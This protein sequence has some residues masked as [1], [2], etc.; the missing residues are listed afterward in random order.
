MVHSLKLACAFLLFA[1]PA[2]A[3]VGPLMRANNGSDIP[4]PAT[5]R[6]NT[7]TNSATNLTTGTIPVARLPTNTTGFGV[8]FDGGGSAIP[9]GTKEFITVPF[10]CTIVAA[11]VRLHATGSAVIDIWKLAFSTSANPTVANTI[12]ASDKPTVSTSIA[13][14][15]TS[16]TSW[17]T[18]ITAGDVIAFNVDSTDASKITAEIECVRT[19]A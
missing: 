3:Q 7:G 18:A 19:G 17:T 16:L 6:S 4:D 5:F 10:G 13:V 14:R 1:A 11:T 15:N 2:A 9:V 8:L 12:T